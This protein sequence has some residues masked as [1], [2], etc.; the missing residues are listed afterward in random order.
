MALAFGLIGCFLL[1]QDLSLMWAV[2]GAIYLAAIPI[3]LWRLASNLHALRRGEYYLELG[4][5]GFVERR[6]DHV[7]EAKW[8]DCSQFEVWAQPI[9]PSIA[10][11]NDVMPKRRLGW[12]TRDMTGRNQVIASV[13]QL[14]SVALCEQLNAYR[15]AALQGTSLPGRQASDGVIFVDEDAPGR[16]RFQI[17]VVVLAMIGTAGYLLYQQRDAVQAYFADGRS[18]AERLPE[19]GLAGGAIL[20]ALGIIL[21]VRFGARKLADAISVALGT[22]FRALFRQPRR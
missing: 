14:D 21:L 19:W 6:L 13:Y 12:L 11:T 9:S 18:V 7:R 8:L 22:V 15:D 17:F 20:L 4:A 10:F 16:K 5:I 3:A 2:F 1:I